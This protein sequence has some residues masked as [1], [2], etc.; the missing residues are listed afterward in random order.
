MEGSGW[1]LGREA[2]TPLA[3]LLRALGK[4]EGDN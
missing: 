4:Y 1:S 3:C 2:E